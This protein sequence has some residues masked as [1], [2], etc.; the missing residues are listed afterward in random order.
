[1]ADRRKVIFCY[2]STSRLVL[3]GYKLVRR[4]SGVSRYDSRYIIK[5]VKHPKS[6]M[7]WGVFSEDKGRGGIYFL[8]KNVTMRGLRMYVNI[9]IPL[10]LMCIVALFILFHQA[11]NR[12]HGPGWYQ[13]PWFWSTGHTGR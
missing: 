11:I 4:P 13:A 7:V 10:L 9:N 6:V 2:E 3:R 8:P 5:T 12:S 1:M